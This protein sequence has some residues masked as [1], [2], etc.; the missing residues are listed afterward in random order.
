[1]EHPER[2]AAKKPPPKPPKPKPGGTQGGTKSGDGGKT[3]K[4]K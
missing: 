3:R 1:M 4:G 2:A